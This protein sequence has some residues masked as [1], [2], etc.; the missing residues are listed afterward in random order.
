MKYNT[1]ILDWAGTAVDFGCFAPVAAFQKAFER[2]GL[3]P[4]IEETRAPMGMKKWD[5]IKKMLSGKRLA[6]E[7]ME[8][9]GREAKEDDIETIYDTFETELFKV[10]DGYA[11][12][13]PGVCETIALLREKGVKIGSTTGYT[14]KMMQIVTQKAKEYDYA[15][16]SMVT[17]DDVC[18]MGRP[19]PYM[20]WKNLRILQV[21]NIQE[22]VKV[23]DT[24]ADIREGKNAGCVSVGIIKGSSILGWSHE[25]WEKADDTSKK[26]ACESARQAFEAAGADA[27]LYDITELPAFMENQKG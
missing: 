23:G 6:A 17:P 5:H 1:V 26:E 11:Q 10:L 25:E 21:K 27:V 13:L 16:D 20:I 4:T 15:P 3:A 8:K 14:S 24:A 2:V 18:E 19:Y 22:V 12:P 7:F 9:Y